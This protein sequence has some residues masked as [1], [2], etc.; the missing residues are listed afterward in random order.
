M[1]K[2]KLFNVPVGQS[3]NEKFKGGRLEEQLLILFREI[4]E[5]RD[6]VGEVTDHIHGGGEEGI[7]LLDFVSL[8]DGW[9]AGHGLAIL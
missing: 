9:L 5:P 6:F 3:K 1:V 8:A 2:R 4:S 7:K